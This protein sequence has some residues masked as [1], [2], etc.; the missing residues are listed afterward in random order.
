MAEDAPENVMRKYGCSSLEETFLLLSVKQSK[1]DGGT[2]EPIVVE[3]IGEFCARRVH[4]RVL[5]NS[6][7]HNGVAQWLPPFVGQMR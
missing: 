2:E 1:A 3:S 5:R 7:T 4:C 6:T